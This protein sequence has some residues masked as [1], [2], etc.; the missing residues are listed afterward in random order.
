MDSPN[1][2]TFSKCLQKRDESLG[3]HPFGRPVLEQT[4]KEYGTIQ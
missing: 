4:K 3:N 2:L 1:T